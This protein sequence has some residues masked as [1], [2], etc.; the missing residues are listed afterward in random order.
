VP[1]A[2]FTTLGVG[3]AARWFVRVRKAE[4]VAAAHQWA[5]DQNVPLF[6]L[7]GGSN[8]VIAD[9]GFDGLVVQMAV[10]GIDS[11]RQGTE[12]M[13]RAGA[14]EP[15]D[16]LVAAVVARDLAGLE[17]LSGIPGS[18]GGT[19]V[20][21]VG[22]YGQEVSETIR[23]VTVFDRAA[24]RLTTL[25]G[26]ECGFAYRT[27]R[28]RREDA[29]RFVICDVTF[30]LRPGPPTLAYPD[31]VNLFADRPR[32]SVALAEVRQAV[33]AIRRRKGMVI[34]ESDPDTRSVG[35]FFMNPVVD[36]NVHARL[37]AASDSGAPGFP[38]PGGRVKIPAAWLIDRAGVARGHRRGRA[39]VSSK[40]PLALVNLGGA[41]ARDVVELAVEIKRRVADRFG[42]CLRPEPAFVGFSNDA[43]VAYLLHDH[44]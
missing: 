11:G 2:P 41:T 29:G 15:W 25:G 40:H 17:C 12:T 16:D 10:R 38:Q 34:D 24:G 26:G 37:A 8:L 23:E 32:G 33:L 6:V 5:R 13:F 35:S 42:I 9:T 21:N 36:A 43:D 7:G 18:V 1:L 39:G 30:G 28:F 14:G 4:E 20:Q 22:A 44:P 19:P 27:S 3:G 31:V